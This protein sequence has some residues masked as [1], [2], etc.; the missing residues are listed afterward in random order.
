M[1]DLNKMAPR[2]SPTPWEISQNQALLRELEG[3][4]WTCEVVSHGRVVATAYGFGSEEAEANAALIVRA[5]NTHQELLECVQDAARW[6][7]ML[8]P[9]NGTQNMV[10]RF[11]AIIAKAEK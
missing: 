4:V 9:T 7:E 11:R 10:A 6:I 1:K 2:N 8:T 5:V 3:G